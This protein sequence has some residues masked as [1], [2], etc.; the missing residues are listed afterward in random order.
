MSEWV[1]AGHAAVDSG[2]L[3]ISD[4]CY[5]WD[6]DK[7]VLPV[8]LKALDEKRYVY[9]LGSMVVIASTLHGD[10]M[11]PVYVKYDN[12]GNVTA[13]M[14]DFDLPSDDYDED[15]EDYW[16]ED[17]EDEDDEDYT[18][19]GREPQADDLLRD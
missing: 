3:C 10:G 19:Y 4:P 13:M 15:I 5:T 16:G 1:I 14:V 7:D 9:S 12:R 8:A 17:L 2:Q 11:Y 18:Y 6:Y